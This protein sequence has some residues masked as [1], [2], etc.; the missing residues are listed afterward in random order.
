MRMRELMNT[1]VLTVEASTDAGQAFLD[2]KRR[3]VHHLVVQK[4]GKIV[5]VITERD[6]GGP[7]GAA[8]RAGRR[9]EDLMSRNPVCAAPDT[10]VRQAA[11][12]MRNLALGCLLITENGRLRGIVT[13]SDLLEV[14][15]RGVAKP[16]RIVSRPQ[17]RWSYPRRAVGMKR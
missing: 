3:R 12:R 9:V 2:M 10:T 8:T 15:G 13:I 17:G 7:R 5:G 6:L 4:N 11:N 1:K 16:S 14:L